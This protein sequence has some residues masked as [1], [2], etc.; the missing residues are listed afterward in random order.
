MANDIYC[1]GATDYIMPRARVTNASV[2]ERHED[3][4]ILDCTVAYDGGS[5]DDTFS[6]PEEGFPVRI[7]FYDDRVFRFEFY[8]TPEVSDEVET[9]PLSEAAF[10][11]P[12]EL[13]C[14]TGDNHLLMETSALSVRVGLAEWS[15]EVRSAEGRSL[16]TEQRDDDAAKDGVRS[17]PL[18][19]D[20][21]QTSRWPLKATNAG[22]SFK[23]RGDE[24]IFGF[25]ESFTAFE[26]S[27][28]QVDSWVTQ[29]HGA[30]TPHSYKNVPFFLSSNGYGLLAD[31]YRR[32][33]FDVGS[34][35][36]ISK[37]V[38][39]DDD[40]FQFVFFYGP[41]FKDVLDDYTALTGRPGEVPKW[42]LGVWMSRLAYQTREELEGVADRLRE[43]EMPCDVLHLDPPWLANNGLCGLN[44][45]REA[46]PDP[47]GMIENLHHGGFK[48]CL[49]EYPYLLSTTDAFDEARK[50]GYLVNDEAGKPYLLSRL[51]WEGVRGGIVDFSNP[52]AVAWWQAR[53]EHLLEMGVDVFKTDF[54]EYLPEDAVCAD[55]ATGRAS[56][57]RQVHRYTRAVHEA[58]A[59]TRP[60][61]TPL[62]WARPGWAGGQQYPV[63]WGGDPNTTFGAMAASLRGGLSLA[64]SGYAFWSAD[65]GGFHGEPSTELYVRWAQF[66][67]LGNSHARFHGTTPREPW[68]FGEEAFDIVREYARERYRLL[69][70]LYSYA[71][72]APE[73]GIP[74][75]R[76]LVLE[77]QNDRGVH[78]IGDQFM[79]GENL[80]L[81]PVFD[82]DGYVEVYLPPGRWVDYWSGDT[83]EGGQTLSLRVDLDEMPV[84]LRAG[85][86]TPTTAPTESVPEGAF[87]DVTLRVVLEEGN[88]DA[89]FEYAD[90]DVAGAIRV[91]AD[92]DHEALAFGFDAE[93]GCSL[94]PARFD[95][96]VEGV[97]GVPGTVTVE[98]R[99]GR[100]E[101]LARVDADPDAGE[102]TTDDDGTLTVRF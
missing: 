27:G 72:R 37:G 11:G 57:N 74:V 89:A 12:T 29:P 7:R 67:L 76:P 14:T 99:D 13:T 31:T 25:G 20:A 53:H 61:R 91:R 78:G 65:I 70:Y 98:A 17:H 73:T 85:T 92:E 28:Q 36:T 35:S 93:N 77:F 34:E 39:V 3:D 40:N 102:W 26:K 51:S 9:L 64:L 19:F 30:E 42:S 81:A 49:W 22:S 87:E 1:R 15:F 43:E 38:T 59:E 16:L 8:A 82:P 24:R 63:H 10:D 60:D 79:M 80:L 95:A 75:M 62:L 48:L 86:I 45:D 21:E 18:G 101:T 55:G 54:G 44:W 88:T 56:R 90:G 33:S 96:T 46:F 100:A 4:V 23:L 66:G 6:L 41:S 32:V 50:A 68:A 58:M 5:D 47:E 69:P 97:D 94:A 84:F 52:D 83:Y 71:E 2:R